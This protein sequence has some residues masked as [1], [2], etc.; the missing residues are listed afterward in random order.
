M[1]AR[2]CIFLHVLYIYKTTLGTAKVAHADGCPLFHTHVVVEEEPSSRTTRALYSK[3]TQGWAHAPS[4]VLEPTAALDSWD[5]MPAPISGHVAIH[6]PTPQEKS[7][8]QAF[9]DL[10]KCALSRAC[11]ET[12]DPEA[13]LQRRSCDGRGGTALAYLF[14]AAT[15]SLGRRCT[16]LVTVFFAVMAAVALPWLMMIMIGSTQSP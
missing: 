2:S 5:L 9:I 14:R 10:N 1:G 12:A 4:V 3:R 8:L 6:V 13:T 15:S 11:F 7:K 16:C